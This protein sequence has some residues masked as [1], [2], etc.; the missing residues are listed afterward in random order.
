[1]PPA[2]L[3]W[4]LLAGLLTCCACLLCLPA[5][6]LWFWACFA[7]KPMQTPSQFGGP[8]G[9]GGDSIYVCI[10]N[11]EYIYRERE[12]SVYAAAC[13]HQ[14]GH[15][16]LC[17]VASAVFP[18]SIVRTGH[19]HMQLLRRACMSLS[20]NSTMLCASAQHVFGYFVSTVVR[21]DYY[22][23]ARAIV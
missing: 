10:M 19:K 14:R 17:G 21:S 13:C 4:L 3:L 1:M 9:S 6:L 2:R 5:S 12:K 8:P 18:W 20:R 15:L 16:E 22:N 7:T 23:H 11:W